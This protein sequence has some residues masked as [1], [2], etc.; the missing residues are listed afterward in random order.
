MILPTYTANRVQRQI[1]RT[2]TKTNFT[3]SSCFCDVYGILIFLYCPNHR[4]EKL[5][6]LVISGSEKV[7]FK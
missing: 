7:L 5:Y 2:A 1:Q 4:R 3:Y 6:E